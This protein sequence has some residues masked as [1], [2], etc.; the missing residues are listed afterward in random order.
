MNGDSLIAH[1]LDAQPGSSGGGVVMPLF[2]ARAN[3]PTWY[4]IGDHFI[5]GYPGENWNWMRRLNATMWQNFKNF[6]T[7][8]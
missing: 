2:Y 5:E 7:E 6:C 3:D 1:T 4:W 8:Y